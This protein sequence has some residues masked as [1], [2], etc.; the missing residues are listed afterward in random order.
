VPKPRK[1]AKK[2]AGKA[3]ESSR[4]SSVK[5]NAQK[6][7]AKAKRH[8]HPSAARASRASNAAAKS[9]RPAASTKKKV[10]SRETKQHQ[11]ELQRR[12]E[13]Y[14]ARKKE[15][16]WRIKELVREVV[17]DIRERAERA[18]IERRNR[19]RRKKY[20]EKKEK[21]RV[22]RERIEKITEEKK[23]K[24]IEAHEKRA[25][26][27]YEIDVAAVVASGEV[28][29][30]TNIHQD[31]DGHWI[32]IAPTGVTFQ[33]YFIV[34]PVNGKVTILW[35]RADTIARYTPQEFQD[36]YLSESGDGLIVLF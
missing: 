29:Q 7:D 10:V 26:P 35:T 11:S 18:P 31:P 34:N 4:L 25:M 5:T 30:L 17:A 9:K 8:S 22:E 1:P 23:R 36:H 16:Q 3:S 27:S 21:E 14:A 12:R 33:A 20:R 15:E 2:K 28:R 19:I 6:T 24:R 13:Q 32:G